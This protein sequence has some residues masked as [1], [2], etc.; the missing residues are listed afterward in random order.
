MNFVKFWNN[1]YFIDMSEI[2]FGSTK[3]RF[4]IYKDSGGLY[5]NI[6]GL[7]YAIYICE[8]Q[9][10]NLIID[11][12]QGHNWEVKFSD[13]F[14]IISFLLLF[15]NNLIIIYYIIFLL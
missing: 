12:K 3:N 13:F 1:I 4:L 5:H 9:N 11:M 2:K 6:Q 14:K 7:N 10:R 15:N 8:S